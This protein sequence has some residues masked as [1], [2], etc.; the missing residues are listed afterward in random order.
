MAFLVLVSTAACVQILGIEQLPTA[1]ATAD[2]GNLDAGRQDASDAGPAC[3]RLD[4]DPC[5]NG[6][7]H[8]FCDDFQSG[9]LGQMWMP[10]LVLQQ[11]YVR[12]EGSVVL[13]PEGGTI[14]TGVVA[15]CTTT[16]I[17]CVA[18]LTHV[19]H[20]P[21]DGSA[22]A[23]GFELTADVRLQGRDRSDANTEP[24]LTQTL[25]LLA[26][27][28]SPSGIVLS[29][30]DGDLYLAS[31]RDLL[32]DRTLI[33]PQNL[34]A[35]FPSAQGTWLKISLFVGEAAA[36]RDVGYADCPAS[37]PVFAARIEPLVQSCRAADLTEAGAPF[38]LEPFLRAPLI[39]LGVT[40]AQLGSATTGY[41]NVHLNAIP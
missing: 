35:L 1:V 26:G 11:P 28:G 5:R 33:A 2:G 8:A 29:S 9:P 14:G 4:L 38:A 12:G 13:S 3:S 31:V 40:S 22:R 37:G 6:C 41:D 15:S 39:M 16:N 27:E 21:V 19:H 10:Y 34:T 20:P 24:D 23:R 25:A 18:G 30:T 36:A 17:T 7:P 32:T